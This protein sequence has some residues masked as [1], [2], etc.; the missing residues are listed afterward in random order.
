MRRNVLARAAAGVL[1]Q[2]VMHA[3]N[4]RHH[5]ARG[6]G[7][8][9]A[10]L[11]IDD[12]KLK[13][14]R[15]I[16]AV[17]VA[18]HVG[19]GNADRAAGKGPRRQ[20]PVLEGDFRIGARRLA[21]DQDLAQVGKRDLERTALE[22]ERRRQ[23]HAGLGG[24]AAGELAAVG[25]QG[26]APSRMASSGPTAAP[27]SSSAGTISPPSNVGSQRDHTGFSRENRRKSGHF[28]AKLPRFQRISPQF[29]GLLPGNLA[30]L[31][32][33]SRDPRPAGGAASHCEVP[34]R[35][36]LCVN[37][38]GSGTQLPV[39]CKDEKTDDSSTEELRCD[40]LSGYAS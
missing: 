38:I 23:H 4:G 19:F 22:I 29:P 36:F 18:V 2:P 26:G 5:P 35:R 21:D 13:E 7:D 37:R 14:T 3:V 17:P 15:D 31:A 33:I 28:S 40:T 9:F 1:V 8:G 32:E 20:F 39:A 16:G 30:L 11:D 25:E 6:A 24:Q 10:R 27:S 34:D 12:K